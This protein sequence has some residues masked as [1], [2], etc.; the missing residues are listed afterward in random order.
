MVITD[1][2]RQTLQGKR[3]AMGLPLKSIAA[4]LGVDWSTVRKWEN[5]KTKRCSITVRPRLERFLAGEYDKRFSDRLQPVD[6]PHATDAAG[7][8]DL[9]ADDYGAI[10]G[11]KNRDGAATILRGAM[12][13]CR[14]CENQLEVRRKLLQQIEH[15]TVAALTKLTR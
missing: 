6:H 4:V 1:E 11:E 7:N 5:G 13:A 8:G 9:S 14:L 2:M 15:A 12:M 10:L 3:I